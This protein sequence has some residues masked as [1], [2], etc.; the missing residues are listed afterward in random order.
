MV[1]PSSHVI[2]L[3][4]R[5]ISVFCAAW[6]PSWISVPIKMSAHDE[7]SVPVAT[8][9]VATSAVMTLPIEC[10]L[11]SASREACSSIGIWQAGRASFREWFWQVSCLPFTPP[12]RR[13][14]HC[15]GYLREHWRARGA[16][17]HQYADRSVENSNLR[18]QLPPGNWPDNQRDIGTVDHQ[19]L[20]LPIEGLRTR[21]R[22][23]AFARGGSSR[24][25]STSFSSRS[26]MRTLAEKAP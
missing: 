20:N 8:S 1:G 13:L 11:D 7:T 24:L 2:C 25:F 16:R 10:D 4:R 12:R 14:L 19:S 17:P 18:A 3:A 9:P 6:I 26:S 5:R 15:G 22:S 23:R 21:G